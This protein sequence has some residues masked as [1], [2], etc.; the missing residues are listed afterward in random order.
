VRLKK[1]SFLTKRL[2]LSSSSC[3]IRVSLKTWVILWT[4]F[5]IMNGQAQLS[6]LT[7]LLIRSSLM[8]K[9]K[10]SLLTSAR[11]T[12]GK[13]SLKRLLEL[14]KRFPLKLFMSGSLWILLKGCCPFQILITSQKLDPSSTT[15]S[16]T[17]QNISYST[18][19]NANLKEEASWLMNFYLYC[20]LSS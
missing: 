2:L 18:F 5:W 13:I 7:S 6:S 4:S 16:R 9:R 12:E 11:L 14:K 3:S 19:L 17:C 8:L 15:Q 1:I 10:R 20:C